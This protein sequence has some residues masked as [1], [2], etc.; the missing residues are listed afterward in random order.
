MTQVNIVQWSRLEAALSLAGFPAICIDT[1]KKAKT[2]VFWTKDGGRIGILDAWQYKG[3]QD[4]WKGWTVYYQNAEQDG[5]YAQVRL[6]TPRAAV[7]AVFDMAED[8]PLK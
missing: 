2:I 3:W 4:Y 7:T 1:P 8:H 5:Y 6:M